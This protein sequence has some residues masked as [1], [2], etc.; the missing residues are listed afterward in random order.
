MHRPPKERKFIKE[1]GKRKTTNQKID[2]YYVLGQIVEAVN[3]L[4]KAEKV[5]RLLPEIRSNL[6]MAKEGAQN[7]DDIAGIPGRLTEVF[8][9]ITA[10][11]YPAWGASRYTARILLAVLQLDPSR[12]AAMEIRYSEELVELI[13]REA[14]EIERLDV[15]PGK[16]LTDM[17]NECLKDGKLPTAFY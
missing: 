7:P 15:R 6:V 3:M 11:A 17:L 8:G 2:A 16:P 9:R 14:I 1:R 12:R 5:Y 10:P 13:K 4:A